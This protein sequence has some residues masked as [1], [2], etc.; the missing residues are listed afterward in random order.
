MSLLKVKAIIKL[1]FTNEFLLI[2]IPKEGRTT[3]LY[4][5]YENNLERLKKS[6]LAFDSMI[7]KELE[8]GE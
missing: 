8:K 2:T 4:R 1:I 3:Q 5:V 6:I 7:D